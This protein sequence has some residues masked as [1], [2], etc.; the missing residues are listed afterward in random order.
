MSD[1]ILDLNKYAKYYALEEYLFETV[2]KNFK[3]NGFL[4]E[5]EFFS[6]IIWKSNRSKTKVLKGVQKTGKTVKEITGYIQEIPSNVERLEYL[7]KIGGIQIPIA[8]AILTVCFPDEFT[9]ADYRALFSIKEIFKGR[10]IDISHNRWTTKR[11]FE[12]LTL[13]K[14]IMEYNGITTLRDTDKSLWGYSFY[15][16]LQRLIK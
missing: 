16:D 14:E 13:C 10:V 8:S 9:V 3:I 15:K 12:Y 7:S 6:I 5:E 1:N 2:S 4:S 11:Y